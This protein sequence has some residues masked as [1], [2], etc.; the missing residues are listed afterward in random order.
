MKI[1]G[2][3]LAAG[4]QVFY[5]KI[6]G[7]FYSVGSKAHVLCWQPITVYAAFPRFF[8]KLGLHAKVS[9]IKWV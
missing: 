6:Y 3:G 4:C 5:C 9:V 8:V 2:Y 7:I 1:T